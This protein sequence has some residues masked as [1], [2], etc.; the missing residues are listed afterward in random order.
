MRRPEPTAAAFVGG[1]LVVVALALVGGLAER[2]PTAFSAQVPPAQVVARLRANRPVCQG[3]IAVPRPF[4]GVEMWVVPTGRPSAPVSVSVERPGLRS[5][6][7]L[8]L[9]PDAIPGVML[10]ARAE[11][12]QAVPSGALVR[13]CLRAGS[14]QQVALAGAAPTPASGRLSPAAGTGPMAATLTFL[15]PHPP[16]LIG[17]VPTI[18]DRAAVSHPG[19]MGG[20]IYW[21]LLAGLVGAVLLL[22]RSLAVSARAEEEL[23]G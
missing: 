19:W 22:A 2:R 9:G 10:T 7:S 15:A 16:T 3:P 4:S 11:F 14:G 21:V 5:S 1:L 18:F 17:L 23:P 20:W 13:L 8:V 12:G 6:G